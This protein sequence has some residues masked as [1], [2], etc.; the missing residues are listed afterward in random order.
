[1]LLPKRTTQD[2]IE[3]LGNDGL[4]GPSIS[5]ADEAARVRE[6]GGGFGRRQSILA[7]Y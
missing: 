7:D 6:V 3:L 1:M 4:E 5:L 2:L